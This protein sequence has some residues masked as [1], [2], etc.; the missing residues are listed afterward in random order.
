[1]FRIEPPNCTLPLLYRALDLAHVLDAPWLHA[2]HH[3]PQGECRCAGV[4]PCRQLA[5]GLPAIVPAHA[6]HDEQRLAGREADEQVVELC[7]HAIDLAVH[8]LQEQLVPVWVA[9]GRLNRIQEHL[10]ALADGPQLR[11]QVERPLPPAV[12]LEQRHA[13]EVT[14]VQAMPAGRCCRRRRARSSNDPLRRESALDG[15]LDHGR[16]I[17]LRYPRHRSSRRSPTSSRGHGLQV[18]SAT[19]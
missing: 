7:P 14:L 5:P 15:H 19:M 1:M 12:A 3:R 18:F 9:P 13:P 6:S 17:L 10:R 8:V 11:S 2:G 4:V 16:Q